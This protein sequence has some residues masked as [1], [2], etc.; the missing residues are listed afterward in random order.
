[1]N[2]PV[3]HSRLTT[4]DSHSHS[5]SSFVI[6]DLR[7]GLLR[8]V[9]SAAVPVTSTKETQGSLLCCCMHPRGKNRKNKNK[10]RYHKELVTD[11]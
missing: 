5:H 4:H 11:V 7:L 2:Q 8:S 6:R 10:E 9:K 1:M 3:L